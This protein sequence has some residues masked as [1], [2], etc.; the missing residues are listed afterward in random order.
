MNE[1][2][3]EIMSFTLEKMGYTPAENLEEAKIIIFNTCAIRQN[4]E[5]KIYGNLGWLKGDKK[6]SD[7][8]ICVSG[9]MMQSPEIRQKILGMFPNVSIIFGTHN[10][11][12]LDLYINQYIRTGHTIVDIQEENTYIDQTFEAIR[13]YKFKSFVN[14]TYGCNNYCSYCI[15][16]YTRGKERSR[17]LQ[18]I[19]SEVEY[20]VNDGVREITLLGQNVNS[21]GKSLKDGTTFAKL[22]QE[23]NKIRLLKR[24]RFMTPHPRDVS[25]EFIDCYASLEK[26][27]PQLHLPAQSGSNKVLKDMRRS[28]SIEKYYEIVDKLKEKRPDISLSTD[29]IVGFP[30]ET[31]EDFEDTIKLVKRVKFDSAFT[32]IFSPR[33]NTPAAKLGVLDES[34]VKPRF[35][36]LIDTMNNIQLNKHSSSIDTV[37]EVLVEKFDEKTSKSEGR[38]PYGRLIIFPGTKDD[39]G[40]FLKVKIDSVNTFTSFG[41]RC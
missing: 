39:I 35:N 1:H 21:Y 23:L 41:S 33:P 20:L 14:I 13:P 10:I 25:D 5:N 4:A 26:L 29:I 40:Q 15:V 38:D 6:F 11:D 37:T 36:R 28:Y 16:P 27:M 8:I 31:E 18:S 3:S 2:D 17:T 24:I 22:L 34:I 9:C 32:F 19:V 12:K 7:R 30:T